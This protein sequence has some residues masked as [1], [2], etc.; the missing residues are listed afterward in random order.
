ML[1]ELRISNLAL[2]TELAIQ[3]GPTFSVLTGETGAGKSIILQSINLLYGEPARG[4]VRSGAESAVVEALFECA[5]DHPLNRL[6]VEQGWDGDGQVVLKRVVSAT[7]N[8]RYY[9]N[10][11]LATGKTVGELAENLVNIA[12]QH[13]HQQLLSR[14]FQLDFLDAFAGLRPQRQA[15]GELYDR[16][17]EQRQRCLLLRQREQ[18][19]EQ[20]RDFLTFQCREIEEAAVTVDEDLRLEQEKQRLKAVGDLARLGGGSHDLMTAQV[21]DALAEIRR[22]LQQ[23]A[24]FDASLEKLAEDVAEHGYQLEDASQQL[25]SYLEDLTDDPGR[26]DEVTARIDTLQKLKRKY[27]SSLQ[28]VLDYGLRS[29][30]ELAQLDEL[31]RELTDLEKELAALDRQLVKAATGLSRERRQA[32]SQLAEAVGHELMAL[33]LEKASFAVDFAGVEAGMELESLSR[34]G[35]DQPEFLFSAN[36]GEPMKPLAKVAS[37]GELSRLMLALKC[38]LARH[39]RVETVIFD[40]IDAGISGQTAEAVAGKIRELAGHHQVICITHLPQ[41]AAAADAHFTVAKEEIEERTRTT[42][43]LLRAEERVGELARMLDGVAVT[44]KTRAYAEELLDKKRR[45]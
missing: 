29:A 19:K 44:A 26:L 14:S 37:G 35:W 2:I 45:S 42:I 43:S 24:A 25:R 13:D 23:M 9:V 6:L 17:S 15:L 18:E 11:G 12:S 22:N 7:G 40:E 38:L 33:C 41:I 30:A 36:R 5:A 16:W 34:R 32:A 21:L 4:W 8:S 10:G 27:G 39:D 31:D 3:F 1:L 28:E 20:R